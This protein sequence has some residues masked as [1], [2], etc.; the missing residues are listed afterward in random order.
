VNEGSILHEIFSHI[1]TLQDVEAAI[2]LVCLRG[3]ISRP[4][5]NGYTAKITH[6]LNEIQESWFGSDWE[7]L[8]E[9]EII[10]PGGQTRRPD[11]VMVKD[12]ATL[13]V[14]YKFGEQELPSHRD[15]VTRYCELLSQMGYTG[16]KGY[17]WYALSGKVLNVFGEGRS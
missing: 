5:K 13:V 9:A 15:Q 16:V 6:I 1:R 4:E 2:E 8:T 12:G 11:R 3:M 17:L 7:I 10:L 14:D